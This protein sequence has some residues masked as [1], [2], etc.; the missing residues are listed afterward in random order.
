MIEVVDGS[1][2]AERLVD[3]QLDVRNV[4]GAVDSLKIV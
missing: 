1:G 3:Q 2:E 4:R